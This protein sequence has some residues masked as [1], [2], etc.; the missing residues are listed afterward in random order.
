MEL[1]IT[2]DG[3]AKRFGQTE[4]LAPLDLT[5]PEGRFLAMLGPSGCGKTTALRLLAGLE[6]PSAGRMLIGSRDITRLEPRSR[7]VA[8][9][10]QSYALYPHKTVA[11]NIAYPLKVRKTPASERGPQVARVAEMLGIEGLLER[12][13]RQ[14]SGGQR[15]RVALAR[16]I[17]RRPSAFLMDEPLSN[18]DAQLRLQMRIEI[19]RLQ[20]ELGVTTIYVTHDQTEAMTMADLIAVMRDGRLQQLAPPGELYERP[21]NLFVARFCGSPPMNVLLGELTDG[22]FRHPA[23]ELPLG[24]RAHRGPVRLG[25]RP[26]HAELVEPG[27]PGALEGE[28]YVVEPLGNET[29]VTVTVAGELLNVRAPAAFAGR[30]GEA[31]GVRPSPERVH[32]FDVDTG[33]ARAATGAGSQ[34]EGRAVAPAAAGA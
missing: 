31:R 34:D 10:F 24:G 17:V 12:T 19:K 26:E 29:L 25:F 7:D 13:P 21:V 14:L 18:L 3:V 15:Q 11:E 33:E 16:A 20:R 9:V 27:T 2:Y 6:A 23:G 5:V 8:M 22:R 1:S 4:A 30:V 28:I 32:L